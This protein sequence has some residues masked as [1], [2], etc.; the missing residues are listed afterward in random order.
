MADE[1]TKKDS[2]KKLSSLAKGRGGPKLAWKS[3]E[4]LFLPLM[5]RPLI[6]ASSQSAEMCFPT[7]FPKLPL[8]SL[9]YIPPLKDVPHQGDSEL[10]SH[11]M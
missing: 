8:V 3:D 2:E 5:L 1:K 6:P 10:S 11:V 7:A 9:T 4:T